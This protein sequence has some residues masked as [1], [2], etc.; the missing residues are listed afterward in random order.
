MRCWRVHSLMGGAPEDLSVLLY[1]GG[2]IIHQS[3]P[4]GGVDEP[5][6]TEEA[7]QVRGISRRHA[8]VEHRRTLTVS[9]TRPVVV[10]E[11]VVKSDKLHQM[12][13][14]WRLAPGLTAVRMARDVHLLKG[15]TKVAKI[16]MQADTTIEPSVDGTTL[17]VAVGSALSWRCTTTFVFPLRSAR[18]IS[19]PF[20]TMPG[21]WPIQHRLEA[22]PRSEVLCVVLP[23]MAAEFDFWHYVQRPIV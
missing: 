13:L 6:E 3:G 19:L 15:D 18:G 14:V 16:C 4:G 12:S 20:E 17:R 8:G 9:R 2:R 10:I 23:A 22:H 21:D 7:I 1:S 5:S 11:D